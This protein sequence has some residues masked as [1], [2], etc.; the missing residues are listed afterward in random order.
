M[1]FL[2]LKVSTDDV[3]KD[4]KILAELFGKCNAAIENGKKLQESLAEGWQGDSGNAMQEIMKE[5]IKDQGE[6]SAMLNEAIVQINAYLNA[7]R[8][9]DS[10]LANEI[11]SF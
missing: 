8:E 4:L 6:T 2:G 9:K 11:N 1:D 10:Q 7:L 3:E 5:W